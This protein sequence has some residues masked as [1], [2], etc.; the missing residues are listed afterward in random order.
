MYTGVCINQVSAPLHYLVEFYKT[1]MVTTGTILKEP[2]IQWQRIPQIQNPLKRTTYKCVVPENIH[3]P[4]TERIGSFWGVGSS[5]RPK[6]V[7][8]CM[9]LDWNFQRGGGSKEKSLPW[10]SYG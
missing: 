8:K 6:N 1:K 3:N 5:H 4:P 2:A 7:S 9:K 10:W